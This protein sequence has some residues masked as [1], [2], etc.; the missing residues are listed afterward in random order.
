[1]FARDEESCKFKLLDIGLFCR[2]SNKVNNHE[3]YNLIETDSILKGYTK[4]PEPQYQRD[5]VNMDVLFKDEKKDVDFEATTGTSFIHYGVPTRQR[6]ECNTLSGVN[7]DRFE[8]YLPT[9]P[10]NMA[11]YQDRLQHF[12]EN[13]RMTAKYL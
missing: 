11:M 8:Q 5:I 7:I 4:Q 9:N 1:V 6:R 2:Q 3:E 10:Q 13:T 12:G